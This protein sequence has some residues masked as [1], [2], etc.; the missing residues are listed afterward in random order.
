MEQ[1]LS[2]FSKKNRKSCSLVGL[3]LGGGT[4]RG[5]HCLAN[6]CAIRETVWVITPN[7]NSNA[8]IRSSVLRRIESDWNLEDGKGVIGLGMEY[9][10]CVGADGR[11][12]IEEVETLEGL[13][14]DGIEN[15]TEGVVTV[16][17][18]YLDA[19]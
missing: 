13:I 12:G 19:K 2:N 1:Y 16:G 17:A 14:Q 18:G 8:S 9:A 11:I 3:N 10:V 5:R 6:I 4:A 15:R 7:C